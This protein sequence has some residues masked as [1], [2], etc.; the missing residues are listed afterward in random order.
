MPL[1][2]LVGTA[3]WVASFASDRVEWRGRSYRIGADGRLVRLALPA[4]AP[5]A[6]VTPPATEPAERLPAAS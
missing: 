4:A 5:A 2:D 3:L 6:A 1:R